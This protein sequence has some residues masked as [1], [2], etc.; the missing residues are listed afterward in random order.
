M[1]SISNSAS[2]SIYA[3]IYKRYFIFGI[4]FKH[5]THAMSD[6]RAITSILRLRRN[7]QT[8]SLK[9]VCLFTTCPNFKEM[10]I[11]KYSLVAYRCIIV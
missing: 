9:L 3:F 7:I 11:T 1:I 8:I 10:G 5:A 2:S 6:H 4:I